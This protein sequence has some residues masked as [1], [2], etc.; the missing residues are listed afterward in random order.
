MK[1]ILI[2]KEPGKQYKL[3]HP[4]VVYKESQP[5]AALEKREKIG[6]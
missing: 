3:F 2:F 4:A 6:K 5:P 1:K